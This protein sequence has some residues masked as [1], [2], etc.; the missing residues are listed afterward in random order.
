MDISFVDACTPD[1]DSEKYIKILIAVIKADRFNGPPE[2]EYVK[3]L[4]DRLGVDFVKL[5]NETDKKMSINQMRVSRLT[6]MLV[7]KECIA[8]ASLD[9]NFSLAERELVYSYASKLDVPLS[10]VK[11][12]EKWLDELKKVELEWEKLIQGH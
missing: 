1:F 12:L 8:L 9:G 3:R 4:A 10:D 5:W 7:L 11:M 2:A 6:A